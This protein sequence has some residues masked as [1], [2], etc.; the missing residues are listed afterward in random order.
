MTSRFLTCLACLSGFVCLSV[1]SHGF[2]QG[3]A[4]AEQRAIARIQ[5]QL[6]ASPDDPALHYY[7]AGYQ[8][9][10]GD[11]G[12]ALDSLAKVIQLGDGFLPT[13]FGGAD[14]LRDNAV[15]KRYYAAMESS[16]PKVADAPVAFEIPDPN[17]IPEGIAWDPVSKRFFVGSVA[18]RR[19]MQV[20]AAGKATPFSDPADGLQSVLGLAVDARRRLLHVV[21][22]SALTEA[23]RKHL[24][25][26][27]VTYDLE[28]GRRKSAV[29]IAKAGQLNDVA[30]A[31]NGD[32]Y[33][34]DS[35]T[36]AVW[37]VRNGAAAIVLRPGTVRDTNGIA[38]TEDGKAVYAAH[39]TGIVRIDAATGSAQPVANR[40][41]ETV[42][43]IDGLYAYRGDLLG[44][45]N[46][47]NPGRVIRVKLS[48]DG[49]SVKAVET[50]QSHHN[51][52]FDEP[53]TGAVANDVLYVLGTTQVS[54]LN[55]KGELEKPESAKAPKVVRIPL[56]G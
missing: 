51:P 30:V 47:T 28:S 18:Q 1:A 16:L 49:K 48:P 11:S 36:G 34:T 17:Y 20:D 12:A 13:E 44:V 42:A 2:A 7:L 3:A 32:L 25:N 8:A 26:A 23:G 50:L 43:G 10:G 52:N 39:S 56:G 33:T 15:F 31:P 55:D 38:V 21:S 46:V 37:R 4:A 9:H 41:R 45:Q 19:V 22:T 35:E 27:V 6:K 29:R 54:R 53:T 24:L 5:R 14:R 40:L